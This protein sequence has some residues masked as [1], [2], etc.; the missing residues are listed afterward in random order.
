MPLPT[1]ANPNTEEKRTNIDALDREAT[2]FSSEQERFSVMFL[3]LHSSI[4]MFQNNFPH[5]KKNKII[6]DV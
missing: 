3:S 6:S 5:V 1:Q 2:L 4:S